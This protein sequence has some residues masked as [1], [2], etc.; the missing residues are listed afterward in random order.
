M[1]PLENVED[2]MN[3]SGY[4]QHDITVDS[5]DS[6]VKIYLQTIE[7]KSLKCRVQSLTDELE[8]KD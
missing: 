6:S 5:T 3:S 8:M 2:L 4:E 7:I 1:E